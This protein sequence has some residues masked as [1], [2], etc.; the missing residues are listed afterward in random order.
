MR[1]KETQTNFLNKE[2]TTSEK[3][4]FT[5]NSFVI[6]YFMICSNPKKNQIYALKNREADEKNN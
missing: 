1:Y 4:K 2:I 6:L 5:N 3:T